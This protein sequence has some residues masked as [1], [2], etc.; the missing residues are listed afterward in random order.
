M[1]SFTDWIIGVPPAFIGVD[2]YAEMLGEDTR[3]WKSLIVTAEYVVLAVPGSVVA[4][5]L[6]ALLL[7]QARRARGF[8]RTVFYLPVLVPPVASAVLWL[9]IFNPD[10]GLANIVL[11]WLGLPQSNWIYGESSAVPS[12]AIMT[13]WG[14]GN[15]A[16]IFLAALQGVPRQLLEAAEVDGAGPLR[17]VW[18]VTLPQIS[19]IIFF[20][21][22]IGLI[23]AF[24]SFDA[25]FVMTSG[26][27]NNATL[28]YV[29]YLYT[30]AFSDA[31]L[32]YAC[33]LAWVLFVIVLIVTLAVF[34]SARSWVYYE[35]DRR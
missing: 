3:F 29:F 24:Q 2:N 15:T 26:G 8:F 25:P 20:N 13:I 28:F 22:V 17:R 32:G 33:A 30:T 11:G 19:P 12:V 6:A 10:N 31:R 18:H 34:R 5:F 21:V 14:F 35:G 7:H 9:W 1:I 27:P 23:A 16:L 4:A